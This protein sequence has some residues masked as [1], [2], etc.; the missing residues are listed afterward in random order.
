MANTFLLA[1]GHNL[2]AS[3]VE[4]EMLA[5]CRRLEVK[6]A[7]R[8]IRV[9][10]PSDLRVGSS[11]DAASATVRSV[12]SGLSEHEMALDIGPVSEANFASVIQD[13]KTVFWNGPMGVFENP[14]FA[15]GSLAIA[16]AMAESEGYTVVGGGD[17][18][19]AINASGLAAQ[20]DHIS[21]GG[22]ASLEFIQGHILPGLSALVSH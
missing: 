8:D 18:V 20:I 12:E 10:L 11:L 15:Q 3:R 22:G 6:A 21:T 14:A 7:A 1:Q 2:G 19:A 17:S 13:A 16:R 5:E 4:P 9:L